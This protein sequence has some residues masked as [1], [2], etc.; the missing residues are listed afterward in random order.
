MSLTSSSTLQAAQDWLFNRLEEGERCPCCD[1]FAK[2]YTRK[3]NSGMGRSLI[4]MYQVDRDQGWIH[5]P[6]RIPLR[7]R[8]EG[9]LRF[10]GLVEE[11]TEPRDDGGR[12]GWW[13]MTDA[14]VAF[15]L[16]RTRIH[17]HVRIYNN[18]PLGTVGDL[19]SIRDVLGRRFHYDELMG[20]T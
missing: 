9:K 5:L 7:S 20:R 6:T 17:S 16:C 2:I 12:A 15:V 13:R 11:S 3:L 14:G 18:E 4:A 1:Q 19:V 8:E 10:W